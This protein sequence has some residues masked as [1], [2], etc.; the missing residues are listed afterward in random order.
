MEILDLFKLIGG[1]LL[2]LA[3]AEFF[4]NGI[5]ALGHRLGTS[6]NF[7]GSVL[8][9]VGT[10]LPETILPIIAVVFFAGNKG[11]DIGVGAILGAP[12]MLSTL[13]FPL[14]GLTILVG[15]F[16]KKRDLAFHVE[17]AGLRRDLV[18]F[19]FAYSLA[20]FVVP[21][22]SHNVRIITAVFLLILYGIYVY[23][24]LR[25]ES[26]DMEEAEHL[27]FS[28]KNPH[29]HISIIWLQVITSLV[30]M[31]IG[32]HIFVHGIEHISVALGLNPLL[33]S[34]LVAP[35]ATELPEKINSVLWVWRGKDTLAAGN[36]AG[37]MV[38]QSTIP[39]SFGIVFTSWDITG[40]AFTSGVFAIISA[41]IVLIFSYINRKLFAVGFSMGILFFI[42]Y[43][44][45]VITNNS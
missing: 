16:L 42:Y 25:G 8:A 28:P 27:Y 7:T 2:I 21:Y 30:V 12:F 4:T 45:L 29:P 23:L 40:H 5:E 32:A 1:I 22:E 39:V 43:V 34:L 6:K 41:F 19:L 20:L 33:F 14:V 38:F 24:T 31:V 9:A 36:I 3:S 26:E 11:E 10:A 15:Y 37:A 35:I 13:A 44:Y 18:F 17:H